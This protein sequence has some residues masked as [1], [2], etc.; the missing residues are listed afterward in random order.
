MVSVCTL[1]CRLD[2]AAANANGLCV[3]WLPQPAVGH[4][5][6]FLTFALRQPMVGTCATLWL[7]WIPIDGWIY[8][9]LTCPLSK[10]LPL[11]SLSAPKKCVV[12]YCL[13]SVCKPCSS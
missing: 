11:R 4:S 13:L 12:V 8:V 9:T 6:G 10:V 2:M 1:V 7:S 3:W 5:G